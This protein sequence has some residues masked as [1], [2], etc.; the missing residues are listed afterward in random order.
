[1][2]LKA[3][4]RE[5]PSEQDL[6]ELFL[7][8]FMSSCCFSQA[9]KALGKHMGPAGIPPASPGWAPDVPTQQEAKILKKLP[10]N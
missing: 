3:G 7:G 4:R 6:K 8:F 9:H 2:N 5:K 10:V 1:M